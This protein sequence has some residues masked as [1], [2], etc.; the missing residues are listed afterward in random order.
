[1]F[2]W[3]AEKRRVS[4]WGQFYQSTGVNL[5]A[6]DIKKWGRGAACMAYYFL[7]HTRISDI[8]RRNFLLQY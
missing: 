7:M 3:P 8:V 1:L 5:S 6:K 2:K 4:S